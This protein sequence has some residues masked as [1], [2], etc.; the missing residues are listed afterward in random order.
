MTTNLT[1]SVSVLFDISSWKD[2]EHQR[3]ARSVF[4]ALRANYERTIRRTVEKF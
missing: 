4:R 1:F 3:S 2:Y